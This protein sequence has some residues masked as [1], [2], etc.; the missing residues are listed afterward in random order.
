MCGP[1]EHYP[2]NKQGPGMVQAATIPL[3]MPSVSLRCK[4]LEKEMKHTQEK[5]NQKI[6]DIFFRKKKS[7]AEITRPNV[8]KQ[9]RKTFL[10][11]NSPSSVNFHYFF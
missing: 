2:A 3:W 9:S 4:E 10:P 5:K 6:A 8:G 11:L 7:G 1:Y